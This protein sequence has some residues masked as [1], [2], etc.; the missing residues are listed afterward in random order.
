MEFLLR[1]LFDSFKLSKC[2]TCVRHVN[3]CTRTTLLWNDMPGSDSPFLLPWRDGATIE[4][5]RVR[6][7][8][9]LSPL[10]CPLPLFRS[11]K[12]E[13]QCPP[14][15]NPV[16]VV[17]NLA[18]YMNVYLSV[19]Q[20]HPCTYMSASYYAVPLHV[21]RALPKFRADRGPPLNTND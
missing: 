21:R 10:V 15:L 2:K 1:T 19:T 14:L 12:F 20:A 3:L 8:T 13:R 11:D 16:W 4:G 18:E 7:M 6:S 9:T 5:L 17:Q